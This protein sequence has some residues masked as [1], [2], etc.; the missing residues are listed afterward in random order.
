MED[1]EMQ[2]FGGIDAE[3]LKELIVNHA[4]SITLN[5]NDLFSWGKAYDVDV[6]IMD[7]WKLVE[8]Y[9]EYGDDGVDAF[10]SWYEGF[11]PQKAYVRSD[12]YKKAIKALKEFTKYR[13]RAHRERRGGA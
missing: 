13:E 1:E 8:I 11:E 4:F 5:A 6:S 7:L 3:R 12:K 10:L 9:T 2:Y